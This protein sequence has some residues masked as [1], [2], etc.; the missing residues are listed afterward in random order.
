MVHR[1]ESLPLFDERFINYGFNK[2]QWIE[3]LRYFGYEF[4]VLSHAY[5]VDIPHSLSGY[6]MEYRNE[7]K[8]KSV[9]M[10]G[11]YR[12]FLVSMRASHKDESRQLLCLRSDKGISKFTHL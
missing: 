10:L 7:F 3:N 8:S 5:A 6:A 12:R 2:V 1:T 11:L 9:D 4:Y